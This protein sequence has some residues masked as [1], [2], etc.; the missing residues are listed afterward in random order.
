MNGVNAGVPIL[1]QLPKNFDIPR[2]ILS[3]LAIKSPPI[4][5]NAM[6]SAFSSSVLLSPAFICGSV[7]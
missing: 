3:L 5:V 7:N 1:P 2:A 4:V 6:A